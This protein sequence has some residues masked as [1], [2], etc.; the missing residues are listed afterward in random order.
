ME[1]QPWRPE[2]FF[3]APGELPVGAITAFAGQL[4]GQ[5]EDADRLRHVESLGW[6][7]CDGRSLVAHEYPALFTVLGYIYGGADDQFNLPDY[8]GYFLR[9]VTG[10]AVND[11]DVKARK[12]LTGASS[13]GVGSIQGFAV[14]THEHAYDY[15]L[16]T[17]ASQSG[18]GAAGTESSKTQLT[19]GGPVAA[20]GGV[21]V[22][23]SAN[24]TRPINIYVN[25]LI[26]AG[27]SANTQSPFS[28]Y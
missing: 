13:D 28:T 6:L 21:A 8:R 25:Y 17:Q 27:F 11:P 23:V 4:A 24:E 16:D 15:A 7:L 3:P 9:G 19:T 12:D 1:P 22:K 10:S 14:Q 26:K 5:G 2:P 18:A 20:P